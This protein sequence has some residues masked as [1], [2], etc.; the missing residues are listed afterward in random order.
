MSRVEHMR[1]HSKYFPLDIRSIY[2]INGL[3]AEDGYI[4][5]KTIKGMYGF[6]HAAIIS[7]NQLISHTDSYGYYPLPFTTELW[8]H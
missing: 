8:S 3:I 2:Q 1:I 7:Y 4:Y 6:K 5:I